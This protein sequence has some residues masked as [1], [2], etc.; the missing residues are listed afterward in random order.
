MDLTAIWSTLDASM[1]I[2]SDIGFAALDQ[3]AADLGLAPG[4]FTM[5][6]SST[7]YSIWQD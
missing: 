4:W 6:T 2:V 5:S 3:L 1:D 7:I